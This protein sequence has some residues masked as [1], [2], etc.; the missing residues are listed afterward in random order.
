MTAEERPVRVE[1]YAGASYPERPLRVEWQGQMR[2]VIEILHLWREPERR[3]FVLILESL[4]SEGRADIRLR[5][6][7][8]LRQDSWSARQLG[9]F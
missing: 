1:A 2:Q 8:H 7:Y 3:Y 9:G 4:P 6:C 5:L